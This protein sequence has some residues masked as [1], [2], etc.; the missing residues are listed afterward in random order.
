MSPNNDMN[1]AVGRLTADTTLSPE[2]KE[3]RRQAAMQSPEYQRIAQRYNRFNTL[4]KQTR[5]GSTMSNNGMG[6]AMGSAMDGFDMRSADMPKRKPDDKQQCNHL[7]ISALL[8]D[9]IDLTP[10][11]KGPRQ[12]ATTSITWAKERDQIWAI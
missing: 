12:M 9:T 10:L 5:G 11:T 7:N 2:E 8:K 4:D 6:Q 3:A 1:S